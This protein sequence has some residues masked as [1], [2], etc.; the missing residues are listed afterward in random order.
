MR[1]DPSGEFGFL[2]GADGQEVYFNR[3]SV[4][5]G[6]ASIAVG[7]RVSFVEERGEKG[8]QAST[9]RVLNKHSLRT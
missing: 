4:V 8:P 7:S 6:R 5:E 9:V 2:E 1:I 3:N